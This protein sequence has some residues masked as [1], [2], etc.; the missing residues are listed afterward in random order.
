MPHFPKPWFRQDRGLWY[1]QLHGRQYNLGRDRDQAFRRYHQLL[2]APAPV[3]AQLVAGVIDGYLDWCQRHRAGRTYEWYRDHLQSFLDSLPDALT[4]P[5]EELKPFHVQR[6]VDG[7]AGWG[8]CSRRGAMMAVQRAFSWAEKLGHIDR[9]P[10]RGLEKPKPERREQFVTPE[11]W[12]TIRDRFSE[13]DPFRDLIEFC[14]ETGCRPQE[15]RAVEARHVLL[16]R[17]CVA[18]PPEEAKGKKRWRIIFLTPRAAE[19]LT[20]RM[21]RHR[22]GPVFRNEDGTAWTRSAINCRFDRLKKKLG[23]KYALYDLRHGFATR[24]LTGGADTLTVA[25]LMGHVD[26]KMLAQHY[27]HLDRHA[28]F[29]RE[30]LKRASEQ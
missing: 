10:L 21:K 2:A 3:E 27:A 20:R 6:W 30:E 28:D 12:P 13:G 24:M 15:A 7:H 25:A 29:L 1:V 19:I 26:G 9:S 17:S 8:I 18:F 5:V 4:L 22:A 14:W 16:E 11:V 23:V